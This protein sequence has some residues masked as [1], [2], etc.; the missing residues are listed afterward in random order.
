MT[1]PLLP[2]LEGLV[3]P[4]RR[5]LL[6]SR[7]G[8]CGEL[9][10]PAAAI[11]SACQSREVNIVRIPTA[12]EIFTYATIYALPPGYLGDVPYTVGIVTLADGL[13]VTTTL[14]AEELASIEVG[15]QAEF[16]TIEMGTDERYTSF[17]YRVR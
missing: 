12:G 17:A 10:F 6:G 14:V 9:R 11:C 15:A 16:E 4:D 5:S 7:C 1:T 3:A 13:R 2:D 8:D